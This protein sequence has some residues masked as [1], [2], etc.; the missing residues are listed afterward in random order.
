MWFLFS[1]IWPPNQDLLFGGPGTTCIISCWLKKKKE[2][3]KYYSL[4][5]FLLC[6]P[7]SLL[8]S[9]CLS[10]YLSLSLSYLPHPL[11]V[12][13]LCIKNKKRKETMIWC[14]G[15]L[16]LLQFLWVFWGNSYLFSWIKMSCVIS[17]DIKRNIF[18]EKELVDSPPTQHLSTAS[19][20]WAI[21]M[22]M[23]CLFYYKDPV[24]DRTFIHHAFSY[25]RRV[26]A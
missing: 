6:L 12:P 21:A 19:C 4:F 13:L 18:P 9:L 25:W 3:K 15:V 26:E 24:L 1:K 11:L 22:L 7:I 17:A 20:A 8:I 16:K 10:M 23:N 2:K 14:V 5:F